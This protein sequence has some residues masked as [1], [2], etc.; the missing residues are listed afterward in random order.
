MV[1]TQAAFTEGATH[2]FLTGAFMIWVGSLVVWIFL[3]VNHEE[4]ATDEV[5]EAVVA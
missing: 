4:M 2:A 5:P 1:G 3:D